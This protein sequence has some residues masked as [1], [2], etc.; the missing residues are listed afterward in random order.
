MNTQ[1]SNLSSQIA[2]LKSKWQSLAATGSHAEA[3]GVEN[4]IEALSRAE[5]RAAVQHQ[6]Q[7]AEAARA[8]AVDA[9][10]ATLAEIETHRAARG[11]LEGV[12]ADIEA[13]AKALEAA[14]ARVTP[15]WNRCVATYPRHETFK[16]PAQ[17][18]AYDEALDGNRYPNFKP[19]RLAVR[20]PAVLDVLRGYTVGGPAHT[21]ALADTRF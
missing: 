2:A 20:L 14:M 11:E 9:A 13:A 5:A 21:L 6:A 1:L 7:Q 17:Q 3:V 18:A 12:V 4:E 10:T 19:L 16:D 8:R 15:A